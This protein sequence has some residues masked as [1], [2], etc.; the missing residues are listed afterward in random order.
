M[1]AELTKHLALEKEA[2][3]TGKKLQLSEIEIQQLRKKQTVV[4]SSIHPDTQKP[5]PWVMRMCAFVPTNVPIIFGMLMIKSTP[6]NTAFFQWLNQTYNAGMNYGNRNASSQ[7]TAK[8]IMFGY[9]AAVVSSIG[10]GVGLKKA[11]FN[12]TKNLNGGSLILANCLISYVAVATAGFL[13]SLCMRMGEMNKGI[14]VYDEHNEDMGISKV[15]AKKAVLQTASSRLLLSMPTFVIPGVMMYFIDKMGMLPTST[16]P[17]RALEL[18]VVS[19]ALWQAPPLCCAMFPQ[20]GDI[21]ASE[22]EEE[23][24]GKRNSKGEIVEKYYFNKGL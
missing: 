11:C 10:L 6:F 1:Q 3:L 12:M 16:G 15:C 14:K 22:M 9:S 18:F 23:F 4:A 13:N 8:D 20:Y 19:F 7:Q 21:K 5:I 24:R 17:K 2:K